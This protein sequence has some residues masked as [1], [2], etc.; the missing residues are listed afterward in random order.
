MGPQIL[1]DVAEHSDTLSPLKYELTDAPRSHDDWDN[2]HGAIR[3]RIRFCD[4]PCQ[5]NCEVAYTDNS[6]F[7]PSQ[8][9]A[10]FESRLLRQR[11]PE[12]Q[13]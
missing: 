11:I 12:S 9:S 6:R 2:Q 5:A 8:R 3:A 13:P 4:A 10:S 7:A 1:P